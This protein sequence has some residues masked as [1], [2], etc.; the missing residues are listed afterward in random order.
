MPK[1]VIVE[2]VWGA[3]MTSASE[4]RAEDA[5]DLRIRELE[6]ELAHLQRRAELGQVVSP[7]VHEVNEA[8][9]AIG[10]YVNACRRLVTAGNQEQV[11]TILERIADQTIR[12]GEIVHRMRE[13]VG[14]SDTTI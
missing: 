3:N 4:D 12:A 9:T 8:L 5:R 13:A 11:P 14:K 1:P 10:N 7:L 2:Q 6:A